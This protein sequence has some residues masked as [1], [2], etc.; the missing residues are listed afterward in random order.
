MSDHHD[1]GLITCQGMRDLEEAAFRQGVSAEA[2]MDIAG[3]RLGEALKRFYPTPGTAVAYLGRGNNSG[4]ALVALRVLLE[5]GWKIAARCP[6]APPEL[7]V[8]PRRKLRQLENLVLEERP[9]G[10]LDT[11]RPLLLIDGLLGIGARGPLRDPLAALA[12]EMNDLREHHGAS[13]A[14]VDIPSGLNGDTGEPYDGAVQADLTVTI[15][16]AKT[17][18]VADD[19]TNYVGRLELIPLEDLPPP[20]GGDELI[21]QQ[22]LRPLI[23]PRAFDCHKG[24]AGR[25]GIV[26]GSRGMLG[27]AVLAATG[28]LR[29]GAGLVTLYVRE[30]LYLP[31][32]AAGPPPEAMVKP[33][34]NYREVLSDSHHALAIGPGLGSPQGDDRTAFLELL[35]QAKCPL[36]VDADALNLIAEE[37]PATHLRTSM[38][39]TP[40]PGE[41]LRLFPEGASHDRAE[42]ARQFVQRHSCTLLYKGA[43]TIITAPGQ[44]LSYNTTGTPAMATG[45]QGDVLTGLLGALLASGL[46]PLMASCAAAWLAGRASEIARAGGESEQS[47]LATDTANAL[48]RAYSALR[49]TP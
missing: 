16:V 5:A 31:A 20:P 38:V 10:P 12:A 23:S 7:G 36:V 35:A 11:S 21:T 43:R 48:G 13:I 37:G 41:M 32:L 1:M 4:D 39:I 49:G 29:G 46:S 19:A 28:A 24:R 6:Y 30:E 42:T 34:A 26:A 33:I 3:R 15:A 22:G 45:G 47:L 8:L 17:G 18:L 9:F 2:L 27:A 25:V 44:P 40:H 14:A